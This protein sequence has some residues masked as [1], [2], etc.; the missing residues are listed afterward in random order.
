MTIV[1]ICKSISTIPFSFVKESVQLSSCEKAKLW[2]VDKHSFHPCNGCS[3]D[4]I[5][6]TLKLQTWVAY[7]VSS[8]SLCSFSY[9]RL[10]FSTCCIITSM[11][12]L[13]RNSCQKKIIK[14]LMNYFNPCVIKTKLAI[15]WTVCS[16]VL[17]MSI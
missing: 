9:S 1:F 3:I 7:L 10:R 16:K 14:W 6:G 17:I 12:L 4:S 5:S 2:T 11:A 13:I 8:S 15:T